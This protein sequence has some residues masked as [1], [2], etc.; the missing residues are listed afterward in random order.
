MNIDFIKNEFETIK[1]IKKSVESILD[2]MITKIQSLKKIYNDYMLKNNNSDLVLTLDSFHFQT[3]FIE[4]EYLNY[5]KI[6]NLFINRLYGDYYKFY[7]Y[8][9]QNITN[10]IDFIH[11]NKNFPVYKDLEDINYDFDIIMN[12]HQTILNI[13]VDL[14]SYLITM[15]HENKT[16]EQQ[17]S[18]GIN[19]DNFVSVNKFKNTILSERIKLIVNCL[20]SYSSFQSKFLERFLLKLKFSYAQI[21]ADIRIE[22]NEIIEKHIDKGL[23]IDIDEEKK[24]EIKKILNNNKTPSDTSEDTEDD[25]IIIKKTSSKISPARFNMKKML[26][27]TI[28]L[29]LMYTSSI[30]SI[31]QDS[32]ALIIYK[33]NIDIL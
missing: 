19:I 24:N 29:Q 32:R 6:F 4:F 22:N 14:N 21:S 15:E 16:H 12:I 27:F 10:E 25:E 17:S 5:K 33:K 3:K 11:V 31:K 7:K 20:K 23:F 28:F 1:D 8:I 13:V 26:W 2:K 30:T 18:A 9:S